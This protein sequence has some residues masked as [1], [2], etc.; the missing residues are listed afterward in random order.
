MKQ[1]L[2]Q[3]FQKYNVIVH[4]FIA[5]GSYFITTHISHIIIII[6]SAGARFFTVLCQLHYYAALI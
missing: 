6:P 1:C 3:K 4:M 5:K 2:L